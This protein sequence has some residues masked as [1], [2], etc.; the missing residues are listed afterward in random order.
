MAEGKTVFKGLSEKGKEI[1][2][3]YPK[4]DDAKL[5]WEYINT[6]SKERTFIGYQ[7]EEISLEEEV[8]FLTSQLENITKKKGI[9]LLVISEEKVVGVSA[10]TSKRLIEKHIGVFGIS[11][12]LEFRGEGIGSKLMELVIKEATENIPEL[13]M[14]TLGVF[15]NNPLAKEMY[16]KFGFVEYG[17]LPKGIKLEQGHQDHIFMYKKVKE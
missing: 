5:M 14:I 7:G 2:I 12:A 6:L 13:E 8:A 10:I 1:I 9:M 16:T 3:R 15:A 11:I 17:M 4:L